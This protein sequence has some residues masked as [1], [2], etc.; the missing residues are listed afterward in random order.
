MA[1]RHTTAGPSRARTRRVPSTFD[2]P[3]PSG[4]RAGGTR[5]AAREMVAAAAAA[6]KAGACR[7]AAVCAA[8]AAVG[9]AAAAAYAGRQHMPSPRRSHCSRSFGRTPRTLGACSQDFGGT[10]HS[11]PTGRTRARRPC[12]PRHHQ[13][14]H[15][16]W[17]CRPEW[18]REPQTQEPQRFG[19]A[20]L[21]DVVPHGEDRC[22]ASLRRQGRIPTQSR[23]AR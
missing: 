20:P 12:R 15:R 16:A 10:R 22:G 8:A 9:P 7:R 14:E 11:E 1:G 21:P 3:L 17:T 19:S 2:H 4:R 18:A 13:L 6:A 5:A 23:S